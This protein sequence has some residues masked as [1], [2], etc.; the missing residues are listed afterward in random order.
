MVEGLITER[1]YTKKEFEEYLVQI[2]EKKKV[3]VCYVVID[4]L[5]NQFTYGQSEEKEASQVKKA[6][7]RNGYEVKIEVWENGSNVEI[8]DR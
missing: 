7:L 8:G 5:K 4:N 1:L 2:C 6:L 3:S